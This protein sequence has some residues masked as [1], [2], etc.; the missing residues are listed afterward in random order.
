[1]IIHKKSS[2]S[3]FV[4]LMATC[5][6]SMSIFGSTSTHG[7]VAAAAVV[8]VDDTAAAAAAAAS[9]RHYDDG[10]MMDK[11]RSDQFYLLAKPA[12]FV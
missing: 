7:T 2:F 12:V 3:I 11:V 10:K 8:V 6:G 4:A 5:T 9:S 1:M